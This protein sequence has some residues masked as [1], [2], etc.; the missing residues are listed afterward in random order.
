MKNKA[1]YF[2]NSFPYKLY[3]KENNKNHIKITK[4][5]QFNNCWQPISV[6]K[7]PLKSCISVYKQLKSMENMTKIVELIDFAKMTH[8]FNKDGLNTYFLPNNNSF[9]LLSDQKKNRLFNNRK[10]AQLVLSAMIVLKFSIPYDKITS[11][12]WKGANG[13][14]ICYSIVDGEVKINGHNIVRRCDTSNGWLYITNGFPVKLNLNMSLN[15]AISF[16]NGGCCSNCGTSS[17]LGC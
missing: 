6:Q 7:R 2:D 5:I 1:T 13:N 11:Q 4:Y 12:P 17:C 3:I 8:A 15:K 10:Y 14:Y 9:K 16:S